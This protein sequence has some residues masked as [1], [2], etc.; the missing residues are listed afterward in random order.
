MVSGDTH[1]GGLDIHHGG[2]GVGVFIA[3][4]PPVAD[5]AHDSEWGKHE[6][7]N[8]FVKA[9]GRFFAQL[10][11]CFGTHGAL[12]LGGLHRSHQQYYRQ[13][14][15]YL[16]HAKQNY[17]KAVA[18]NAGLYNKIEIIVFVQHMLGAVRIGLDKGGWWFYF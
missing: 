13:Y 10:L 18:I 11:G 2:L 12:G 5:D 4:P 6:V 17:G 14:G 1:H 8:T 9:L 3:F 15:H 16:F 7:Q